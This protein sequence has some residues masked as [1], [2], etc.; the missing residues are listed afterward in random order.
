MPNEQSGARE[1]MST[2]SSSTL[3][4]GRS[5]PPCS[6][7]ALFKLIKAKLL[8]HGRPRQPKSY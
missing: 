1:L 2:I 6:F 8:V 4:Y 3:L 5:V 7:I